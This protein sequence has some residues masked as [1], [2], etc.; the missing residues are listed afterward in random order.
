MKVAVPIISTDEGELLR[1][2]LPTVLMQENVDVLVIDNASQDRTSQVAAEFGVRCL[3]LDER[4]SYGQ[5]MNAAL[6]HTDGDAVLMMQ[7][8]CYLTEG[9]LDAALAPLDDQ[10][11]GS[12]APKLVRTE[13]AEQSQR[14]DLIDTAGMVVDRRRKN[15]LVG[16]GEPAG[17]F[18]KRS[19]AFGADGASA[20]YRRSALEDA[21]LE[22]EI[23]DESL[24]S[25]RGGAFADWGCDADLAWRLRLLGWRCVYEPGALAYHVRRYS[26]TT[27]SRIAEWQRQVQFRN[28]YLMIVKNDPLR[29]LLRDLPIVLGYELVA[30]GYVLLRERFL[31]AGYAQAASLLPVMRRKRRVLQRVSRLRRSS[32]APYG[33]LPPA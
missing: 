23:F 8:D 18:T 28:R 26:P 14:L 3:R 15:G 7:P 6:A 24:V 12:V 10:S 27:R 16:H 13:G 25:E 31:L 2:A 1:H 11:V 19:E 30:F 22:G 4:R 29:L 20:L 33:L 9:F 21:A 17:A 5:A 32:S